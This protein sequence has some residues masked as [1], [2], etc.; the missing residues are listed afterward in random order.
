MA[1]RTQA[2]LAETRLAIIESG[3]QLFADKGFART[4][5][6]E[7]AKNAGVGM[8]AFYGQFEDKAELFLLIIGEVF[9]EV[10]EGIVAVRRSVSFNNPLDAI[11][12]IQRTYEMF[13]ETLLKHPQITLS[14]FRSGFSAIPGLEAWYWQ[15][16]NAVGAEMSKDL[17]TGEA[18]GLI[19]VDSH[20]NMSDAMLGMVQH[21][22]YR[23]VLEGSPTPLAAA[24]M[25][26]RYTLGSLLMSMPQKKMIEFMPLLAAIPEGML[27]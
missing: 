2:Q 14:A 5:V 17:A 19:Q 26:T 27:P 25:C 1:R 20:R 16:C 12:Q 8:S 22:G 15:I 13:F 4:Q 7:I 18:S 3:K 11:T 9:T 10:H 23:M 24:R 21:L 6:A